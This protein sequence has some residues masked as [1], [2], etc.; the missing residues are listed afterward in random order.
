MKKKKNSL[1]TVLV[2][3]A[4]VVTLAAAGLITFIVYQNTHI[5]VENKAYPINAQSLDLREEDIS[6]AHFDSIHSQLP[7]CQILWSVPFQGGKV[8]SDATRITIKNPSSDDIWLLQTYFPNLKLIDASGCDNYT[9]L[10]QLQAALPDVAV[11]YTVSLGASV[12]LPDAQ[13][14]NLDPDTFDLDTLEEGLLFLHQVKTVHLRKMNLS[15]EDFRA[16]QEAFP[17][18]EFSYTVDI[19]GQEMPSDTQEL[20]LSEITEADLDA[21]SAN[22]SLLPELQTVE[23]CGSDGTSKLSEER[24]KTI[25]ASAPEVVFHYAFDFFGET[26]STDMEEVVLKN[27]SIG[28]SGEAE[29]RAALDLLSNCKRFV[30]EN[31]GLS[32]EVLAKIRDDYRDRTKVVWRVSFGKGTTMTDAE[33]IR[34]VYDLYDS[35]CTNLVY[36]ED[37]RYA[38]FGHNEYLDDW[39]F[40]AGMKSLEVLIVS[41]SPIKDLTPLGNCKNLRVLELSNCGYI[42]D[43]TPLASCDSL[44]ML[45]ISY[46]KATTGLTALENLN[47]THLTAVGGVWS[48]ISQEDKDSFQQA[49]PDCWIVTAGGQEYGVGWRYEDKEIQ[50]DWYKDAAAAFR[51]PSPP[52]HVG[53]YL[54][55][56]EEDN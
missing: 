47:I 46:T 34:A 19:L 11:D 42:T 12:A 55:K 18:I 17:D 15:L 45:N 35:N 56:T 6:F 10:E 25:I 7:D 48:K 38:D 30:L 23:L 3:V 37:A 26:L 14:L 8:S 39:S 33:V 2:T 51:Y 49:H 1:V 32:N 44:E 13:E 28:D 5:F 27:K 54:E 4:I 41:G 40:L 43:L 24:A 36:C 9:A 22:L 31:C 52:N 20:D 16:M 21:V 50:M 29:V 53:W